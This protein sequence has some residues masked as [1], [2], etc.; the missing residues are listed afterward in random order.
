[1]T[2]FAPPVAPDGLLTGWRWRRARRLADAVEITLLGRA[3]EYTRFAGGRMHQPQDITG[4]AVP[5]PGRRRRARRPGRHGTLSGL[6]EPSARRRWRAAQALAR[7]AGGA[8]GSAT[9]ALPAAPRREVVLWHDDTAAFD[10]GPAPPPPAGRC[11]TRRR[12]VAVP[13]ACSAG[14]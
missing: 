11:G 1:M 6:D 7:R 13:P 5:R 8:S 3:G 10:A 12:P 2:S 9:V 14:R 4:D